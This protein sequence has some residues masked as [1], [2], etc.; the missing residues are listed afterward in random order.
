MF[1]RFGEFNSVEELNMAAEGQ[2]KEG[3]EVSF[4]ALAKEN[5]IDK[6][7]AADYWNGDTDKL[8]TASMAAF[9]RLD[10]LEKEEIETKKNQ[11]EKM[12]LKVILTMLKGM[13]ADEEMAKAV[14]LKGKRLAKILEAMKEEARKY[15]TGG[16]A[17]ACG[18]DRQ[19]CEII[20]AYYMDTDECFKEK[21]SSIYG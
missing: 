17:M 1:D 10:I 3:D 7:D 6:E 12:P 15:K 8:A 5:G 18:T 9:G 2:K 20:K 11:V 19:L 14:M 13:C 21:I 16:M 4:Y